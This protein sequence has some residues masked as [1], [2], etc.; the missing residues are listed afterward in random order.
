MSHPR[1]ALPLL[2]IVDD[3]NTALALYRGWMIQRFDVEIGS[4]LKSL[5]AFL[6]SGKQPDLIL[7]DVDFHCGDLKVFRMLEEHQITRD[8]RTVIY[9]AETDEAIIDYRVRGVILDRIAKPT[10]ESILLQKLLVC[11]QLS[12]VSQKERPKE[13]PISVLA[14]DDSSSEIERLRVLLKKGFRFVGVESGQQGI[15][16]VEELHPDVILLDMAMDGMNGIETLRRLKESKA[17]RKTPIVCVSGQRSLRLRE[18]AFKY[19]AV[20]YIVKPFNHN[21]FK[22]RIREFAGC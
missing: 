20:D 14:I 5:N 11:L 10:L 4:D 22:K 2:L 19:G 8:V 12:R 15:D 16:I 21:N 13:I 6:R 7:L 9:S 1:N 17:G 18:K 3:D